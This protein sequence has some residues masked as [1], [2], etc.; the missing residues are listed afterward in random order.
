MSGVGLAAILIA[1]VG[2]IALL[3]ALAWLYDV[4]GE[5]E[6]PVGLWRGRRAEASKPPALPRD[7]DTLIWNETSG[8]RQEN[9]WLAAQ[10]SLDRLE[11]EFGGSALPARSEHFDSGWLDQRLTRIETLAGPMPG[12]MARPVTARKVPFWKRWFS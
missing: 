7:F 12:S 9:T 11:V 5:P 4:G 1:V 8:W 3:V 6:D 2:G 10:E